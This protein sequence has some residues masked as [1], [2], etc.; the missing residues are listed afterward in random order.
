M[1]YTIRHR[2]DSIESFRV[3]LCALCID[4]GQNPPYIALDLTENNSV[5]F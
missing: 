3:G 4:L 2:I 1:V 5:F